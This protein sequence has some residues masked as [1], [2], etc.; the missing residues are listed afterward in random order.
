MYLV[1]RFAT[2]PPEFVKIPVESYPKNQKLEYET[3]T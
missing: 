3:E 1:F 2:I